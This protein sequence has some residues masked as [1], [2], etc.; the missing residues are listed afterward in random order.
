LLE[1]VFHLQEN[2]T[3]VRREL[4]AGLTIVLGAMF[5]AP[6]VAAVPGYPIAPA[7][8]LVGAL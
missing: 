6:L 1:R 2:Q 5:C 8:I 7:L 3:I 4:F